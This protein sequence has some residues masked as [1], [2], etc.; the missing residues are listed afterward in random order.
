MAH[1]ARSATD[2]GN[3]VLFFSHRKEINEQVER[4]F[5]VNG[6]NSNLLT[7]GGVQS[8]VRKLDNLSQPEVILIDEAHHSKA[9]SYLK[10]IDYFKNAYVLM[11]TGTPVRLNGDGFDDIA[12]DLVVGK[13]VK[14]LQE[15]GN[16]AN[17]KYYAPSMID[18]SV[19]KKRGGEFTKDSVDQSM[20]SVIYGDV[21][22]HY[23]KL[24]KGK[25]AIVYT[26][27]LEAS[28]LVSD[29]FNQA[30]YQS[31]A[32]SG[33]TPK[34]EREEAM[35][36]FRDGD[37]KIMVNCELFTEGIDLPNVDVC[38]MLRPTQS[39]SLYLQFA[40]RPLNP[41]DGKTAIIIDHVG[42]VERFGLPN[43][44]REWRLDGKTK[45]KQSTKIGEPTTRV[46]DDCY[47]TYWSDARICPECGHENELTK[48][49]IEEIKEAELQEISEQKQL[50]LKNRVST[51]QTPDMCQTMD[52]L[53]EYRKQ[54][55][56][57]P[58]WQYHIAKKLGILY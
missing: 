56:Y 55:G 47:A 50:K 54:H 9:K 40:M 15:H 39:L 1:I 44:D 13:S 14:W 25:Q 19:L 6:V 53:T 26:H 28:D 52:E 20:K 41:R 36:A 12:D 22:K 30:G 24:A 45:Q 27:S 7:V 42:N 49:E 38:I 4:T 29:T 35:R 10:I 23:E 21:I 32:V 2:K 57:K 51:Y 8:L 33:K 17:F 37:L 31:Q 16:I 58:G 43:I 18:N 11:F 48:R 34:N 3:R 46:C 5:A